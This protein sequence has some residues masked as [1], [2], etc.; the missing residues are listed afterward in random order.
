MISTVPPV[1]V[2][3]PVPVPVAAPEVKPP[4]RLPDAVPPSSVPAPVPLPKRPI[5]S[6][7]QRPRVPE[8]PAEPRDLGQSAEPER[9]PVVRTAAAT[10][11]APL[12]ERSAPV[13]DT[14]QVLIGYLEAWRKTWRLRYAAVDVEDANGGRVTLIGDRTLDRLQEGQRVRVHGTV[15]P[16]ADRANP[17]TFHVQRLEIVQ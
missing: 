5:E 9:G 1:K 7:P 8:E 3:E 12:P 14:T 15:I 2:I 11:P 10:S 6:T 13:F 4:D 17:P 16:A